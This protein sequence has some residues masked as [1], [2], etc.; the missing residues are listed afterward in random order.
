MASFVFG[1]T[2]N[3]R[4]IWE[5]LRRALYTHDFWSFALFSLQTTP[6]LGTHLLHLAL[7]SATQDFASPSY[8]LGRRLAEFGMG[9]LVVTERE[10]DVLAMDKRRTVAF[11]NV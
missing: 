2:Q 3:G 6:V 1:D 11:M 8:R 5:A 4:F 9:C 10:S 7:V